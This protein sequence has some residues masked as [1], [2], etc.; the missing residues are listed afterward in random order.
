MGRDLV[1]RERRVRLATKNTGRIDLAVC[2]G[3][4]E[5]MCF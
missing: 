3:I 2:E 1:C 4:I 5:Q